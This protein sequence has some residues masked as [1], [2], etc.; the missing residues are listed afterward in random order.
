M[1]P[2]LTA[3]RL[4]LETEDFLCYVDKSTFNIRFKDIYDK[5]NQY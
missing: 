1:V 3:R 2:Y 4:V 5:A